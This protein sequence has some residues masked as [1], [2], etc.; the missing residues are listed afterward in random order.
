MKISKVV[1]WLRRSLHWL[2]EDGWQ[3]RLTARKSRV[4]R[5]AFGK[6][7]ERKKVKWRGEVRFSSRSQFYYYWIPYN[8][9]SPANHFW[10]WNDRLTKFVSGCKWW[11]RWEIKNSIK[12]P[13]VTA[14]GE[15][16]TAQ[17][18]GLH[19][20]RVNSWVLDV[21]GCHIATYPSV[22]HHIWKLY[23]RV[24]VDLVTEI[25]WKHTI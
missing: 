22:S 20:W 24:L 12:M 6:W 2:S 14:S 16:L 3:M 18:E 1:P 21:R 5:Q 25:F 7:S 9:P 11:P 8:K 13:K 10:G 17:I 19:Y 15:P 4:Q 23:G